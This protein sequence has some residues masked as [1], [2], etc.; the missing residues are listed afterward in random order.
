[1]A[2]WSLMK[3]AE[4]N[5]YRVLDD[6]EFWTPAFC[7]TFFNWCDA[8][9]FDVPDGQLVRGELALELAKKTED[10]HSVAKAY[11]VKA[12]AYRMLSLYEHSEAELARAFALAGSC[13]CCLGD[14]YRRHGILRIH[15]RRFNE[16]IPLFDRAIANCRK[17]NNRDGVGR[18]L[19]SRGAA[20]CQLKRIDEALHDE[21]Q[22]LS[23]LSPLSPQIYHLAVLTNI[24]ACLVTGSEKHFAHAEEYCAEF[25]RYLEGLD[26]FTIVRIRLS[27][28]HGVILVRLGERKRGLQMLR[29]ARRALIHARCDS[30]VIA[31][32]ADISHIYC[33]T[34]K[35]HLIVE[36]VREVLEKLGDVSGTRPLLKKLLRK[37]ERE[38]A[39]TREHALALRAAVGA[40][41]PCLRDG[42]AGAFSTP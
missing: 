33:D 12:S 20:L 5:L 1:M 16:S 35:Y 13:P 38:H 29:K 9:A 19:V 40:V 26:G 14:L 2:T 34:G 31:I 8:Q 37:A 36:L 25:R 28:A 32:T 18:A 30:E 42:Q 23:L 41:I 15:Q 24:T 22:A 17:N 10:Q 21:H 39:E 11:G 7:R 4:R 27:W 6:P 3:K